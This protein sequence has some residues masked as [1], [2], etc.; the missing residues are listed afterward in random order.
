MEKKKSLITNDICNQQ[1]FLN[2]RNFPSVLYK[3]Q[4]DF[5][6]YYC[7]RELNYQNKDLLKGRTVCKTILLKVLM[8][9]RNLRIF[10]QEQFI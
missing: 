7:K 8:V 1:F 10:P 5:L 4:I 6:N 2:P 3:S 9:M